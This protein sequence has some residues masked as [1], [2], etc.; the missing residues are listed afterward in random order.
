MG[1][2]AGYPAPTYTAPVGG[3][4]AWAA[5]DPS[6]QPVAHIQHRVEFRVLGRLGDWA[7]IE[8]SNGWRAWVDAR[9]LLAL[10]GY[11]APYSQPRSTLNPVITRIG[12]YAVTVLDL[13]PA[14]AIILSALLPWVRGAA[15]SGNAFKVPVTLLV[16]TTP[17]P[18]KIGVILAVAAV[19][20]AAAPAR[21]LRFAAY[22]VALAVLVL[23]VISLK[24]LLHDAG[25][26]LGLGSVLGVGVYVGIAAALLGL[27]RSLVS[28]PT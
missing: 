5:P 4:P 18:I 13:I 3:L 12:R 10:N 6:A 28:R 19:V 27:G 8:C 16:D 2:P 17:S 23:Y 14:A 25:A 15:G 11:S 26:G 9:N 21:G 22:A 24:R 7:Q 1:Q 20:A